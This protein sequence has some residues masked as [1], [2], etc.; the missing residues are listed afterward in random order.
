MW[1][2]NVPTFF[3]MQFGHSLNDDV[4]ESM[5]DETADFMVIGPLDRKHH[6]STC[7]QIKLSIT[8]IK[9]HLL[10]AFNLFLPILSVTAACKACTA[11]CTAQQRMYTVGDQLQRHFRKEHR[12]S[13]LHS[14]TGMVN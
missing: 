8:L 12:I 5:W 13:N 10:I 11:A 9:S 14:T 2:I 6:I 3:L 4:N 7:M 1:P